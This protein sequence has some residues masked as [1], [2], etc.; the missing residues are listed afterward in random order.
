M[1]T[2]DKIEGGETDEFGNI[3]QVVY[4]FRICD[5]YSNYI[6]WKRKEV[7]KRQPI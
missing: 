4:T 7:I 6:T 5:D 1:F 2:I 3:S